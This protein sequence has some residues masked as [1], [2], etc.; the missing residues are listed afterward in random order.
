M[1][2]GTHNSMTYLKPKKWYMYPFKFMAKCQSMTIEEQYKYGVRYFDLRI[3]FDNGTPK[4]KHG[5]IT[6]EGDV[7]EVLSYLNKCKERV[8]VRLWLECSKRDSYQETMFKYTCS[9]FENIFSK[10][11]FYGGRSKAVDGLYEFKNS[12]P[13]VVEI[14]AS[15]QLPYIDDLWPWLYAK[16][17]NKEAKERF[18]SDTLI[19]DFVEIG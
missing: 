15:K 4:F 3:Y 5:L 12:T 6:Y 8:Y 14:Y 18:Y 13:E 10:I 7:S 11:R 17:H 16:L 9:I 2:L 19:L 1:K